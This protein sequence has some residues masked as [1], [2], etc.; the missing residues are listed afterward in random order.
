M[1]WKG[2]CDVWEDEND[3]EMMDDDDD[4]DDDDDVQDKGCLARCKQ[5]ESERVFHPRWWSRKPSSGWTQPEHLRSDHCPESFFAGSPA[6]TWM[7]QEI[8]ITGIRVKYCKFT[9]RSLL[10]FQMFQGLCIWKT[11]SGHAS[12]SRTGLEL[13][14][15]N[16]VSP[17]GTSTHFWSSLIH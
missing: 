9:L 17:N 11:R 13:C 6:V 12:T 16:W 3:Q 2:N 1:I 14:Q 8:V 7:V 15:C 10:E 4:D 5:I